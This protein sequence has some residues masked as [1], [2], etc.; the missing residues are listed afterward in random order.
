MLHVWLSAAN[1]RVQIYQV[2]FYDVI[3]VWLPR[4]REDFLPGVKSRQSTSLGRQIV[5]RKN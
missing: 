1:S 3:S 4:W 5:I 2:V